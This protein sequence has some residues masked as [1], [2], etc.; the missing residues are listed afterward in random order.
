MINKYAIKMELDYVDEDN[1]VLSSNYIIVGKANSLKEAKEILY[2]TKHSYIDIHK[3]YKGSDS[4]YERR[5]VSQ[6]N[7]IA[8]INNKNIKERIKSVEIIENF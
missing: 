4:L 3:G 1:N 6:N 8:F 7:F 2:D 5:R